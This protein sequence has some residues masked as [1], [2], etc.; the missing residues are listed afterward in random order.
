LFVC[1]QTKKKSDG[2]KVNMGK[3]SK[4]YFY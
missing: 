3:K 4:N 1:K 2:L